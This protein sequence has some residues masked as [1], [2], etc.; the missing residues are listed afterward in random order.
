MATTS[1]KRLAAT[2]CADVAARLL[3]SVIKGLNF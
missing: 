2:S 1:H 3:F